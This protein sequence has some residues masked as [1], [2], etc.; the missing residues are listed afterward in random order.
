M[1]FFC[2]ISTISHQLLPY[3]DIIVQ[4]A[5]LGRERVAALLRILKGLSHRNPLLTTRVASPSLGSEE[6][7]AELWFKNGE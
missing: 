4:L 5:D 6:N 1:L 2:V 7:V 3:A